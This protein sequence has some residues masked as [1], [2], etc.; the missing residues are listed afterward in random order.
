MTKLLGFLKE[1]EGQ[2]MTE[3]GLIIGLIVAA[4]VAVF[5]FFGPQIVAV[6]TRSGD[7]LDT[8]IPPSLTPAP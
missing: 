5:A 2:G 8:A 7:A 6:F 4:A 1:E 3:Y